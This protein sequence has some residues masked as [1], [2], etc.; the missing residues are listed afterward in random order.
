[1]SRRIE[2]RIWEFFLVRSSTRLGR[3]NSA[4]PL[5][6]VFRLLYSFPGLCSQGEGVSSFSHLPRG[7]HGVCHPTFISGPFI[8]GDHL[9]SFPR[10]QMISQR[11]ERYNSGWIKE[12]LGRCRRFI[13]HPS[14]L[15]KSDPD[16][17]PNP[18]VSKSADPQS[19]RS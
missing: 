17:K 18:S 9:T 15:L 10:C 6:G 12:F 8:R 14:R 3:L 13:P 2:P 16:A 7:Y 19:V 11:H 1:M 5:K 4:Q